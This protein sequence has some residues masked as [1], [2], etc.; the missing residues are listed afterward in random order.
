M[1]FVSLFIEQPLY[2]GS[3]NAVYKSYLP[4]TS[5]LHTP[6]LYHTIKHT[7]VT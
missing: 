7:L 5:P 1:N 3:V 6:A 2:V 4:V